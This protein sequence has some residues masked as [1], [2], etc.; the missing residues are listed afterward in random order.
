MATSR[1][2]TSVVPKKIVVEKKEKFSFV[3]EVH[4]LILEA[5]TTTRNGEVKLKRK[6]VKD[7]LEYAFNRGVR[8]ATAGFPV[9]FPVIGTLRRK[10]IPARKS[11]KGV[12]PF[13]GEPMTFKAR[14]ASKKPAWRFPKVA[15]ETFQNKRFW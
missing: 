6:D 5:V 12:N 7:I 9:K 4:G 2:T 11:K 15:R 13:T 8:Y 10:D 14:T 3:D 1:T